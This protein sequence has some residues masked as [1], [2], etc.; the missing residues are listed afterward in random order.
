M[1]ELKTNLYDYDPATDRITNLGVPMTAAEVWAVMQ[2]LAEAV[3]P[4]RR[5]CMECEE[6]IS[7]GDWVV[8]CDCAD[9]CATC[10]EAAEEAAYVETN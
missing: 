7:A 9:Y 4:Q 6:E 5:Q 3:D 1:I 10:E 2:A 8:C